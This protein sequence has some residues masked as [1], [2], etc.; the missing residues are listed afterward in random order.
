[1][2]VHPGDITQIDTLLGG[3]PGMTCVQLVQGESPAL[4]DCGAQTSAV[5]VRDALHAMG[6]GADDLAWLVLTHVHLD[7]CGAVG[8]LAEAF[9]N[10]TVVV[11]PR[12]ARHLVEPDRLVQGTAALFG[13]LAPVMG[14]LLAVPEGR[15]VIAEDGHEVALGGGRVLRA[16]HA[17]G[18]ARHHMALLDEGEGVLFSGDAIG[19]QMGGGELYPSLPPPEYD[20]DAALE[21]LDALEALGATRAY[22]SHAGP[23]ADAGEAFDQGRRA[24][25]AMGQ[26]ARESW[27]TAPGDVEALWQAVEQAW[28]SDGAIA[29]P[30]ARI[31]WTAFNWLDNNALGLAGMAEREARTA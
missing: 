15:I 12:G 9:P 16:V 31:R 23:T 6:I 21:T 20:V 25:S 29:T 27:R 13:N 26:A 30:E 28:P 7:H 22:V 17:P 2:D 18:H 3:I 4:I 8:D 24:Q 11:H 19:V 1:M 10:A 14:G 5:T